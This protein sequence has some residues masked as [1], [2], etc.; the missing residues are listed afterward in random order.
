MT[1]PILTFYGAALAPT[2]SGSNDTTRYSGRTSDG[3]IAT[4]DVI[5]SLPKKD[6]WRHVARFRVDS[7]PDLVTGIRPSST[8]TVTFDLPATLTPADGSD[9]L[10]AFL[11]LMEPAWDEIAAGQQ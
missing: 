10:K 8:F 5:Q 3:V 9:A 6:R 1:L 4:L 11:T 7:V 2:Y